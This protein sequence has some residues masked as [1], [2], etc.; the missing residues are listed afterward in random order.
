MKVTNIVDTGSIVLVELTELE[1]YRTEAVYF[2]PRMF[3]DFAEAHNWDFT[4]TEFD[5]DGETVWPIS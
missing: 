3:R 2:D 1:P 5:S 4:D